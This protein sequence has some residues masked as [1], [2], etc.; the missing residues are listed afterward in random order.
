MNSKLTERTYYKH[1]HARLNVGDIR[2]LVDRQGKVQAIGKITKVTQ[3]SVTYRIIA[4][5]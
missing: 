5:G 4:E 2:E 3:D 1:R